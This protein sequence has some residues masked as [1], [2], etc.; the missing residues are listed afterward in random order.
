[1]SW[2]NYLRLGLIFFLSG[3]I[4]LAHYALGGA[5][6][7]PLRWDLIVG[8]VLVVIGLPLLGIAGAKMSHR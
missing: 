8:I 2:R 4:I 3:A 1:M 7:L 6:H 5:G